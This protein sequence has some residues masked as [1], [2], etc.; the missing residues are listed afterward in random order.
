MAEKLHI[1]D[2][3]AGFQVARR[4]RFRYYFE[5]QIQKHVTTKK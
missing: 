4:R 1:L 2:H 5:H 3:I